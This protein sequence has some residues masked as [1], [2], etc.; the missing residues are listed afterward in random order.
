MDYGA[1]LPVIDFGFHEFSLERLSAY[2]RAARDLDFKAISTNDHLIH[3]RPW[4]DA[5]TALAAILCH[6]GHMAVGTSVSL[7]VVRGPVPDLGAI[8]VGVTM[9]GVGRR[10][11][12][13]LR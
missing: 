7:L 8:G 13:T 12:R 4:L 10:A 5:P 1:H 2:V 11:R 3:S 6:S 9:I